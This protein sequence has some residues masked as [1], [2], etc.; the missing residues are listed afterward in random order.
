LERALILIKTRSPEMVG[1]FDKIK[2]HPKVVEANTIYGPYDI[3]SLCQDE[4]TMGIKKTVLEIRN[5]AGVVST[6]TCLIS[7]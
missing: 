1:V 6:L 2:S 7:E 4:T 3:Y 5:V